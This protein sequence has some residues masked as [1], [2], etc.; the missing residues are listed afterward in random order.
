MGANQTM[1][2][3]GLVRRETS[4]SSVSREAL[5]AAYDLWLKGRNDDCLPR[6]RDMAKDSLSEMVLLRTARFDDWYR[7]NAYRYDDMREIDRRRARIL[8]R[9]FVADLSLGK[10]PII[11][12]E[13]REE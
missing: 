5:V 9:C 11:T 12:A 4:D 3:G 13:D 7:R 1:T 8:V 2:A 6:Q 10:V